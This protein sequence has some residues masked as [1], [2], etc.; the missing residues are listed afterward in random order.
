MFFVPQFCLGSYHSIL[1]LYINCVQCNVAKGPWSS[2][3]SFY[4]FL[5]ILLCIISYSLLSFQS[6]Y[7]ACTLTQTH[8]CSNNDKIHIQYTHI[9]AQVDANPCIRCH[10]H[11]SKF[12][13]FR[14]FSFILHLF[15]IFLCTLHILFHSHIAFII[16]TKLNNNITYYSLRECTHARKHDMLLR[17]CCS[18]R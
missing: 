6:Y 14:S 5:S 1:I 12:N 16:Y 11:M 17:F 7:L 4:L 3:K 18:K 9:S 8:T 15:A 13:P 10:W 2:W